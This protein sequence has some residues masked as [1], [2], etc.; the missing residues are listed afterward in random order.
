MEAEMSLIMA[1]QVLA[2]PGKL[3]YDPFGTFFVENFPL[4]SSPPAPFSYRLIRVADI[5]HIHIQLVLEVS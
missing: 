2:M 1:N 4:L 5:N 3:I